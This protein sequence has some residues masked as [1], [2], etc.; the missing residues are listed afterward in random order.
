MLYE[1]ITRDGLPG[2]AEILVRLCDE[3]GNIL[4]PGTFIPAAERF[5][6]MPE[7]DR[8]VIR[9]ACRYLGGGGAEA[10]DTTYAINLSGRITSYNVCYTKLL[11]ST[12]PG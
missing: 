11:R 9:N 7:I 2:H 6:L 10:R 8:W 12:A 4:M 3:Q 1:V 5:N